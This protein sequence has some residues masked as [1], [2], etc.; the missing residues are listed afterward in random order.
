MNR[1]SKKWYPL[2]EATKE[3]G[4]R[5]SREVTA[6]NVLEAHQTDDSI[7]LSIVLNQAVAERLEWCPLL[8]SD[9][10][11]FHA[12]RTIKDKMR[13]D[14]T[15]QYSKEFD[16]DTEIL[17]LANTLFNLDKETGRS[18][19]LLPRMK[20]LD[21][22]RTDYKLQ[23]VFSSQP[24]VV[25]P[26]FDE[27][28]R[29]I[30]RD[31]EIDPY[32]SAEYSDDPYMWGVRDKDGNEYMPL[33]EH[34][35]IY[36]RLKKPPINCCGFTASQLLKL[37]AALSTGNNT[38]EILPEYADIDSPLYAK[39][40]CIAIEAHKAVFVD[41]VGNSYQANTA[42]IRLWLERNHPNQS[43]AFYNRIVT[44]VNPKK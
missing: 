11:L 33:F 43:D 10:Y 17:K 16:K 8:D 9:Y 5:L 23:L 12:K 18:W 14:P 35:H 41:K 26:W 31:P 24:F 21:F 29:A 22:S 13:I 27:E 38:P 19:E 15:L 40:L 28:I 7:E 3:L 1:T 25:D 42:K 6:K 34:G 37:E 36:K 20:H 2:K 4:L 39:E 32:D 30:L 44:V